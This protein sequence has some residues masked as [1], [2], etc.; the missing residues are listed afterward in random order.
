[1]KGATW[2]ACGCAV[3]VRSDKRGH[4]VQVRYGGRWVSVTDG[5]RRVSWSSSAE[6]AGER[7]RR[8]L[9]HAVCDEWRRLQGVA[10]D[11]RSRAKREAAREA[12]FEAYE[13]L[14]RH[15]LGKW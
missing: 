14:A 12:C 8:F 3:R 7:A 2:E 1:M 11:A 6:K 15:P 4:A 13:W 5:F 9:N 10:W